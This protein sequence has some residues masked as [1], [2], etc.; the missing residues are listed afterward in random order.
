MAR[1][2]DRPKCGTCV[3]AVLDGVRHHPVP[4]AEVR[5]CYYRS[6]MQVSRS[7]SSTRGCRWRTSGHRFYEPHDHAQMRGCKWAEVVAAQ[8][9]EGGAH[10]VTVHTVKICPSKH[11]RR[12][13]MS[14]SK[15]LNVTE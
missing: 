3:A 6:W 2:K 4:P 7:G 9:Q 15:R 5:R 10:A 8:G 13:R 12:A 14:I 1:L 11:T